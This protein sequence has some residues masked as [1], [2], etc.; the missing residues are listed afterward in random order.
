MIDV[1]ATAT[2]RGLTSHQIANIYRWLL[3]DH[4]RISRLHHGCCVGGDAS[5]NDMAREIGIWTVGH[6]PEDTKYMSD[7]FVDEMLEPKPYLERDMNIVVA[8]KTLLVAP[9]QD[10]QPSSNRGSGTW[11]TYSYAEARKLRVVIFWPS[12]PFEIRPF[13]LEG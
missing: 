13:D 1:G 4:K 5:F 9:Y 2:R 12:K 3:S 10:Y 11:T 8:A 6:P 7:C